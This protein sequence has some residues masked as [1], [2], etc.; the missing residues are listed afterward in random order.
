MFNIKG[1]WIVIHI[2]SLL[3]RVDG[4][5]CIYLELA[6]SRG[7]HPSHSKSSTLPPSPCIPYTLTISSLENKPLHTAEYEL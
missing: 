6:N 5:V 4:V 7:P 3:F 2:G 1:I